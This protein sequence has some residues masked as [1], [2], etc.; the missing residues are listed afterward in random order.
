[1]VLLWG[2][3]ALFDQFQPE[4]NTVIEI[5]FQDADGRSA[6]RRSTHQHGAIPTKVPRPLMTTRIEQRNDLPGLGIDARDVRP[7]VAIAR[8][9]A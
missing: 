4:P 6:A 5:D 9:A 2:E 8:E 7:F 1:M 3:A